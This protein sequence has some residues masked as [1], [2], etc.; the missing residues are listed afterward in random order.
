MDE[1]DGNDWFVQ[2]CVEYVDWR[3]VREEIVF[4]LSYSSIKVCSTELFQFTIT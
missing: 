3:Q 1:E 4:K 2:S